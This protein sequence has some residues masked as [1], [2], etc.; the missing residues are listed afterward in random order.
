MN[1]FLRFS[2][3][4]W[5][6]EMVNIVQLIGNVGWDMEIKYLDIGKVVVKISLVVQKYGLKK[7]EFFS[8]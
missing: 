7:D 2:S 3:V 6:K 1:E 8:W 5:L 4:W